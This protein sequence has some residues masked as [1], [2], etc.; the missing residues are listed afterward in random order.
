MQQPCAGKCVA[1]Y[2]CVLQRKT[3]AGLR[4]A[5]AGPVIYATPDD[6]VQV[7]LRN[8]LSFAI[9]MVPSG[10]VTNDTSA[11]EP[12][13]TRA[14][15][16]TIPAEVPPTPALCSV[17]ATEKE[18][19]SCPGQLLRGCRVPP[20]PQCAGP[21]SGSAKLQHRLPTRELC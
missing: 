2:R 9:N 5:P 20:A 12:N 19:L 7:V 21:I 17:Q 10:A 6:D 8:N 11:L 3:Q 18:V 13:A 1:C 4:C 15:T 14:Y 16:W